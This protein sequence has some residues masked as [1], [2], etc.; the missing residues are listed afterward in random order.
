MAHEPEQTRS[1]AVAVIPDRT[2]NDV[3]FNYNRNSRAIPFNRL[4]L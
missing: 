3:R 4:D 1:S 2:A